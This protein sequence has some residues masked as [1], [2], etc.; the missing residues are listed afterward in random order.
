MTIY[1]QMRMANQN[2]HESRNG[3]IV[4]MY[5]INQLFVIVT[6]TISRLHILRALCIM[7]ASKRKRSWGSTLFTMMT[8]SVFVKRLV[9]LKTNF[10]TGK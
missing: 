4:Y 5:D 8:I 6:V 10:S 2:G 7:H 3:F 9:K 1:R